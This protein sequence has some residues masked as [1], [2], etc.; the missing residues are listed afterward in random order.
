MMRIERAGAAGRGTQNVQ[1][2]PASTCIGIDMYNAIVAAFTLVS[3]FMMIVG[4]YL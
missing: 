1:N 4:T 2:A 3:A